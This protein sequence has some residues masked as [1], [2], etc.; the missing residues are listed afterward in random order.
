MVVKL[1]KKKSVGKKDGKEKT[2]TNLFIQ[3]DS[4]KMI[5]ITVKQVKDSSGKVYNETDYSIACAVAE[6]IK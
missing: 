6:E 1:L 3:L 2:Y 4:G 5:P